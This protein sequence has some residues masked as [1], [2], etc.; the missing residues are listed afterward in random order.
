MA[1]KEQTSDQKETPEISPVSP[2]QQDS[3]QTPHMAY[4]QSSIASPS[5]P[6]KE[7]QN[8]SKMDN[9]QSFSQSSPEQL[10]QQRADVSLVQVLTGW[11]KLGDTLGLMCPAMEEACKLKIAALGNRIKDPKEK[12]TLN[13]KPVETEAGNVCAKVDKGKTSSSGEG[14]KV[15]D[16]KRHVSKQNKLIKLLQQ[17]NVEKDERIKNF[18]K[19]VDEQ[20]KKECELNKTIEEG[21]KKLKSGE[22]IIKILT[23]EK[24]TLQRLI[25]SQKNKIQQLTEEVR[26]AVEEKNITKRMPA[27]VPCPQLIASSPRKDSQGT[28]SCGVMQHNTP[29]RRTVTRSTTQNERKRKRSLESCSGM[30]EHDKVPANVITMGQT[31]TVAVPRRLFVPRHGV[32]DSTLTNCQPKSFVGNGFNGTGQT[33]ASLLPVSYLYFRIFSQ[34]TANWQ[35]S[36]TKT[37]FLI[38]SYINCSQPVTKQ[39]SAS[40]AFHKDITRALARATQ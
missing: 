35:F 38:F 4:A 1:D 24:F 31:A 13:P 39:H 32:I 19:I 28:G 6:V 2:E 17:K 7:E 14:T 30:T 20:Q 40:L 16:L 12:L 37:Y 27:L 29:A 23:V 21:A 9:A 25:E 33:I 3:Q 18:E 34:T 15:K 36:E 22:G 11:K 5:Q 26:Q 8:P 10:R